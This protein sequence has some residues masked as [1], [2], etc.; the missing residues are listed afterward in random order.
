MLSTLP[1]SI[2]ADGRVEKVRTGEEIIDLVI[3]PLYGDTTVQ[4][5]I[6][7]VRRRQD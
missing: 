2:I 6:Q 4:S 1:R 7:R 5:R 3:Q